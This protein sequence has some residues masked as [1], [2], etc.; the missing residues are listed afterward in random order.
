MKVRM[1][2]EFEMDSMNPNN[3]VTKTPQQLIDA[4]TVTDHETADGISIATAFDDN[5][6][7]QNTYI[8]PNSV[9]VITKKNLDFTKDQID[10]ED[11]EVNDDNNGVNSK[12]EMYCDI[13]EKFGTNI[14]N[15]DGA[16]MNLYVTYYPDIDRLDIDLYISRDDSY[17]DIDYTPS[18]E[19]TALLKTVMEEYCQQH[20]GMSIQDLIAEYQESEQ[21][22]GITGGMS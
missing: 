10:V 3:A 9:K 4:L 6:P 22:E 15:E 5:E 14:N 2:I 1:E 18:K 11:M 7:L 8:V 13:D 16:W 19:E 17:E 20:E 12:I 21:E